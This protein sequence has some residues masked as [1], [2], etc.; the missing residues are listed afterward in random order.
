VRISKI[1]TGAF[2]LGLK[3]LPVTAQSVFSVPLDKDF[4]PANIRANGAIANGYDAYMA[5]KNIDGK[6]AL[7][8]VGIVTNIQLNQVIKVSLRGGTVKMNGKTILKD[9]RFFAKARNLSALPKTNA[10]CK[11]TGVAI[12]KN[13]ENLDVRYGRA[14][15]RN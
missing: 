14:T 2:L 10:N 11:S 9:F 13:I 4:Q 7:C 15:F 6:L 3:A 1:L 12:P 5:L 8:G